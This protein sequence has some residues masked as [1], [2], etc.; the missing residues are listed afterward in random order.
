[1]S[2]KVAEHFDFPDTGMLF[3]SPIADM[4]P[5]SHLQQLNEAVKSERSEDVLRQQRC[6]SFLEKVILYQRGKGD[7]PPE[8]EFLQFREDLMRVAAIK[9]LKAGQGRA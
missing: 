2:L 8:A 7:I 5:P 3:L 6:D 4:S 1:M 9:S